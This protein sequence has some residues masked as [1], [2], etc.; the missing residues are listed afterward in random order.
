[1]EILPARDEKG[2]GIEEEALIIYLSVSPRE[3]WP[4]LNATVV[5]HATQKPRV[6][7]NTLEF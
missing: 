6:Y 3:R 7:N 4:Y 2:V 5:S 1:M